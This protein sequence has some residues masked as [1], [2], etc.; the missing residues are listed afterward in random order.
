MDDALRQFL[1]HI[2]PSA[3]I[4]HHR[5][6]L[7]T[8]DVRTEKALEP[9]RNFETKWLVLTNKKKTWVLAGIGSDE[10]ADFS[11]I[12]DLVG[13]GRLSLESRKNL[14]TA[15][16]CYDGALGP[17]AF[18]RAS[19]KPHIVISQFIASLPRICVHPNANDETVVLS[20]KE[21]RSILK[22]CASKV[23]VLGVKS[24]LWCD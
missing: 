2:A 15:Q 7:T 17:L 10:R 20:D 21:F 12:R 9:Y 5:P 23:S 22:R 6:V 1:N 13:L 3:E 24:E 18:F 14:E 16:D 8:N 11:E 19:A 4:V